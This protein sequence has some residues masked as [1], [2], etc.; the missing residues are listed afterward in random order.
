MK[1]IID[2]QTTLWNANELDERILD[3]AAAIDEDDSAPETTEDTAE[4]VAWDEPLDAHGHQ[5]PNLLTADE[6]TLT[7]RLVLAGDEEAD[8]ELREAS[9]RAD[10][11]Q[12]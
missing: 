6:Q 11:N 4:L 1:P 12:P 3:N 9:S 10:E 7:E 8:T 2:K 5:V